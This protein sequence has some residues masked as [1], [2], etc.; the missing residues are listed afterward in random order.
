MAEVRIAL[1]GPGQDRARSAHSA[2]AAG[3]DFELIGVASPHHNSMDYRAIDDLRSLIR[4]VVG[5]SAVALC[6]P[7]QVRYDIA[8]AALEH[9]LHVL[10][11]KPPGVTVSEVVALAEPCGAQ[12]CRAVR[13]LALEARPRRRTGTCMAARAEAFAASGRLERRCAC[14]ASRSDL[15]MEGRRP[16]CVRSGHQCI[17]DPDPHRA[18]SRSS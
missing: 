16:G 17:V 7:P 5:G 3:D 8:R 6:T 18:R 10:L 2:L 4:G 9:G 14:L 11:E 15:D 1:V 13:L 12:T